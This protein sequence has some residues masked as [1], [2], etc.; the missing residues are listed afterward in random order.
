M[1]KL[2][3]REVPTVENIFERFREGR[4]MVIL[5]YSVNMYNFNDFSELITSLGYSRSHTREY[6]FD[7]RV[8]SNDFRDKTQRI[9]PKYIDISFCKPNDIVDLVHELRTTFD[10]LL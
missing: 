3:Y 2:D 4:E 8:S 10:I 7:I 9:T 6:E 1:F 5:R